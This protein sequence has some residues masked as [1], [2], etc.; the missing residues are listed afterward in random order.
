MV[1]R[2]SWRSLAGSGQL[3]S[4]SGSL[5]QNAAIA[6]QYQDAYPAHRGRHRYADVN[7]LTAVTAV[8]ASW[9]GQRH[10]R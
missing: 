5:N 2:H 8:T 10:H 7:A 1:H 3:Q 9:R 4:G 6:A